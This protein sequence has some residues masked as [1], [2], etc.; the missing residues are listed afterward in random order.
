MDLTG[1]DLQIDAVEDLLVPLG[2]FCVNVL[3]LDRSHW[4]GRS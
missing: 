2:D 4:L 1:G 3:E